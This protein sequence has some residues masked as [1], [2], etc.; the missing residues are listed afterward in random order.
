MKLD[1]QRCSLFVLT[2]A[3]CGC[4]GSGPPAAES[5]AP[6]GSGKTDIAV[7]EKSEST[8][9]DQVVAPANPIM[10][11]A[12]GR[13]PLRI[14]YLGRSDDEPRTEAFRELFTKHFESVRVIKR[15]DFRSADA[16]DA[17]VV[18][19]DW[20]QPERN[21]FKGKYPSPLGTLEDWSTPLVLLGSA[22]LINAGPWEVVG[23]AG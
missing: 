8:P 20:S 2:V 7:K 16:K 12:S 10:P 13:M 18:V 14:V 15:D 1:L 11:L 5:S 21:V 23:G 9:T 19:L 22:G 4:G 17:D 3:V 6:S